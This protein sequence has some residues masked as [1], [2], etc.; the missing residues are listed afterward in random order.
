M[1]YLIKRFTLSNVQKN[2]VNLTLFVE[3]VCKRMKYCNCDARIPFPEAVLETCYNI[4]FI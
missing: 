2:G 3:L 1:W 4:T